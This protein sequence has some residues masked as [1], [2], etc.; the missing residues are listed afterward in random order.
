MLDTLPGHIGDMQEAIDAI[1][2]KEYA[3]VGD[4]FDDAFTDIADF[5]VFKKFGFFGDSFSFKSSRRETTTFLRS[6]LI[7]RILNSYV[8]SR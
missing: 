2:V 6:I 7:L 5:D 1:Q 4:V 3:E 8:L